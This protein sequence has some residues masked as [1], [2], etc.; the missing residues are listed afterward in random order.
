MVG[1]PT[2]TGPLFTYRARVRAG[3]LDADPSQELLVEKLH[4]LYRAL[5]RLRTLILE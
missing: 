2:Q 5:N 3:E 4:S 1:A